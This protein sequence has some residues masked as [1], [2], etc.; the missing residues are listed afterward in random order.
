MGVSSLCSEQLRTE[1]VPFV[2][3]HCVHCLLGEPGEFQLG[4]WGIAVIRVHDL[5]VKGLIVL[6]RGV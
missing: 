1:G 3:V 4:L 2:I 6:A 5:L